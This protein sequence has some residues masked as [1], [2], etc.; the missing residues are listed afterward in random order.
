MDEANTDD[1]LR[2]I[3]KTSHTFAILG[4]NPKPERA[5]HY[6]PAY[7]QEHGYEVLPVNP[8]HAGKEMF[9]HTVVATLPEL[10]VPVDVVDV[11]RRPEALPGHLDEI[12]AMKPLPKVVWFQLGIRNDEV[13]QKLVDAGIEVVQ[14]HCALA[15][16]RR[17]M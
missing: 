4:A 1:G 9:G 6:V 12:L 7:L 16:H 5:A 8:V 14:D 2:S 17:L 3:L 15:E 10:Q 13:A 11:F